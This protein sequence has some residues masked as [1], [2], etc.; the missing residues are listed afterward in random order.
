MHFA[1]LLHR[2]ADRDIT[3]RAAQNNNRDE[4]NQTHK[5]LT[6]LLSQGGVAAPSIECCEA[7]A[8]GAAGVVLVSEISG[9]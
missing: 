3:S 1:D 4:Q 8:D 6:P 5:T 2:V 7:T 9:C